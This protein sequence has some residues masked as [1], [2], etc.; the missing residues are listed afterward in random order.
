MYIQHRYQRCCWQASDAT[1]GPINSMSITRPWHTR[2]P[3]HK[4]VEPPQMVVGRHRHRIKLVEVHIMFGIIVEAV[5]ACFRPDVLRS[6]MDC[7]RSSTKSGYLYLYFK[8][9]SFLGL[10]NYYS[11]FHKSLNNHKIFN[12]TWMIYMTKINL[13]YNNNNSWLYKRYYSYLCVILYIYIY[14]YIYI[15]IYI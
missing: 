4:N 13:K 1:V 7:V 5:T 15:Y 8:A 14:K 6:L 9:N 2:C 10:A 3:L 11:V 12:W